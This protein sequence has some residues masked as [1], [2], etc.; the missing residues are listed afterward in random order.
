MNISLDKTEVVLVHANEDILT[1]E[2]MRTISGHKEVLESLQVQTRARAKKKV[3]ADTSTYDASD[4]QNIVKRYLDRIGKIPLLNR[5]EE[6]VLTEL[7]SKGSKHARDVLVLSNLRLVVSI[8]KKYIKS[9]LF[10]DLIQEGTLGLMHSVDKFECEKGFKFSTYATWWINQAV[11][12]Y[13][14]NHSRLI[15]IPVNVVENINKIKQVTKKLT[16]E[17]G[18]DPEMDEIAAR[19]RMSVKK[20]EQCLAAE[21]APIS[22]DMNINDDD[23]SALSEIIE[24]NRARTPE[25]IVIEKKMNSDIMEAISILNE[26][27]QRII[28]MHFGLNGDVP[29]NLSE[30]SEIFSLTRERIRQIENGAFKKIKESPYARNLFCYLSNN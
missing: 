30:I 18:R 21:I 24:D 28:S 3:A 7:V 26:K 14:A 17:L 23:G 27:E 10:I 22:L 6:I 12:R 16:K 9:G 15:R 2:K 25:D 20:I 13:L 19:T 4:D 5:E 29:R 1:H 8:A 11:S